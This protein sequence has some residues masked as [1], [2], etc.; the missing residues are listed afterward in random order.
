[1]S[2]YTQIYYHIIFSTKNREPVLIAE[3][4]ESLFRYAWGIINNKKGHLYRKNGMEDHLHILTSLHP[5]ISLADF[6]KD[7]KI[8]LS[9]WIKGNSVFRGFTNWQDGYGAFTHSEKEKYALIEYIKDQEK[10][11]KSASF[12]EEYKKLLQEAGIEF[13]E[14]YLF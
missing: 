2:T 5:T 12:Q 13:Q 14:K 3:K 10:H 1:M 6:V 7:I 4:R 8:S 11:H 9:K